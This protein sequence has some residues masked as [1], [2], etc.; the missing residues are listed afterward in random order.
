MEPTPIRHVRDVQ[1]EVPSVP[2]ALSRVGVTNVEK[3][4]RI[5]ANGTEQ[6]YWAR[7]DCFVDLGPLQ[8]G[9]HMSRFDEVINDAIGEVVIG[10]SA[11]RAETLAQ[12]VAEKVRDRQ[13]ARRAEVHIE[14]RYPEHKPAPESGIQTQEIYSLLAVAVASE[15]GTRRVVGVRAQGMTACPCAQTLVQERARERLLGDG[16]SDEDVERIFEA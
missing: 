12:H 1:S 14:A 15:F 5:R 9:A 3:V 16:F 13:R 2:I 4:I 6:L 8:K 11:L 7:L 10:E